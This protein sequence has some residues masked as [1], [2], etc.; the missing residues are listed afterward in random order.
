[1]SLNP[2]DLLDLGSLALG[3][4]GKDA[5]RRAQKQAYEA[6]KKSA[7][8]DLHLTYADIEAR[9]AEEGMALTQQKDLASRTSLM[10]LGIAKLSAAEGGVA[11]NSVNAVAGDV[12]RGLGEYTDSLVLQ[13]E[14]NL[15]QLDRNLSGAEVQARSRI[16]SVAQ[17]NAWA[18]GLEMA[19][20]ALGT[21][22]DI[23]GRHNPV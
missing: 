3:L 21:A 9:K 4:F 10:S 8:S 15:A 20:L 17:P 2:L 1:M 16:A 11:G 12:K 23:Y 7:I 6:N 19:G 5:E 13:N 22:K 14:L 18:S